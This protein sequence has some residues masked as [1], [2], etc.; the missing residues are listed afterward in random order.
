M[1]TKDLVRGVLFE[2]NRDLASWVARHFRRWADPDDL[3]QEAMVGLLVAAG[4]F[5]PARGRFSS[6]AVAV[7][8]RRLVTFVRREQSWKRLAPARLE[9]P[10]GR[11]E[12]GEPRS[13]LDEV[14]S[15]LPSPEEACSSPAL[16]A[17]V[18]GALAGLSGR[19]RRVA[20]DVL[21]ERILA[22]EPETLEAIGRRWGVSRQRVAQVEFW[23]ARRLA[24][25]FGEAA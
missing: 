24:P 23:L 13:L 25:L 22:D 1:T 11:G 5:D 9:E 14:V 16:P 19:P 15:P 18:E 7:I 17:A 8:D 10:A 2:R 4:A 3:D 12:D 20:E 21:S 6:F